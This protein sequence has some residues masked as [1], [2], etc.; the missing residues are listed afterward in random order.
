MILTKRLHQALSGLRIAPLVGIQTIP[1]IV[2]YHSISN[3]S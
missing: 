3:F 2:Q 1:E